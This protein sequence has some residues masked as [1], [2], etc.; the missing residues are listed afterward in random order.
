MPLA[1][2]PVQ[3]VRG[4]FWKWSLVEQRGRDLRDCLGAQPVPRGSPRPG[5]AGSPPRDERSALTQQPPLSRARRPVMPPKP[6]ISSLTGEQS[7]S[8]LCCP[9]APGAGC[10]PSCSQGC[11]AEAGCGSCAARGRSRQEAIRGSGG[12]VN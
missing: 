2:R 5:E 8:C 7:W 12:V 11:A 3:S 4:A 6:K 10:R 9:Q 1:L